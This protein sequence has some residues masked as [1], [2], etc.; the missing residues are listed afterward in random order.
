METNHEFVISE[1][2]KKTIPDQPSTT[3]TPSPL[4]T[5]KVSQLL[6][7]TF[8]SSFYPWK[9]IRINIFVNKLLVINSSQERTFFYG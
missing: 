5:A 2:L 3:E 4:S 8:L 6:D 1:I 7:I 9:T